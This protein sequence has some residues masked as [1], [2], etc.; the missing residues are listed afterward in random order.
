M[1]REEAKSVK[2]YYKR[3]LKEVSDFKEYLAIADS[4]VRYVGDRLWGVVVMKRALALAGT[5]RECMEVFERIS[6]LEI[7]GRI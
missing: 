2:A 7:Y 4:A 6:S 1:S 5:D 3:V